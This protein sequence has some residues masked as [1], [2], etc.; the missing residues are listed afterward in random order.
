MFGIVG[1]IIMPF[2]QRY[3]VRTAHCSFREDVPPPQ[4]PATVPQSLLVIALCIRLLYVPCDPSDL[5]LRRT[6]S[7]SCHP[8]AMI[9]SRGT[10][11]S[12]VELIMAQVLQGLG[13]G[14]ATMI[15]AIV[16]L[17]TK[18]GTGVEGSLAVG[19][20][21][22]PC[23]R[24]CS[25]TFQDCRRRS[26][27]CCLA[28]SRP[29]AGAR[30]TTLRVGVSSAVSLFPPPSSYPLWYCRAKQLTDADVKF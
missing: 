19:S 28:T 1:G 6:F 10:H 27:T 17:W 29:S 25:S 5:T 23:P 4:F 24:S 8:A 18:I 26:G 20:G 3:K 22:A 21:L 11:S 16:L 9:P 15:L 30:W 7:H 14:F 12:S 2:T 13:G